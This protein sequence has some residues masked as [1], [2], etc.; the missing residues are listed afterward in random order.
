M[1]IYTFT[2]ED[3]SDVLMLVNLHW[4]ISGLVNEHIYSLKYKLQSQYNVL[5]CISLLVY[6]FWLGPDP[7]WLQS[8]AVQSLHVHMHMLAGLCRSTVTAC[9]AV[10][11][12]PQPVSLCL[13]LPLPPVWVTDSNPA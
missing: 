7:I 1:V 8:A 10:C 12:L 13:S 9:V 5:C 4:D 2:S 6:S 11:L 3:G